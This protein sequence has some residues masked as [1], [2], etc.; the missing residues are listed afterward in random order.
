MFQ[1]ILG[2]YNF[3]HRRNLRI[4]RSEICGRQRI[5]GGTDHRLT[6]SKLGAEFLRL[7][8]RVYV[9]EHLYNRCWLKHGYYF[10]LYYFSYHVIMIKL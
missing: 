6:V 4:P 3:T 1:E 5:L 10:Y 2:V 9:F 7:S 8:V